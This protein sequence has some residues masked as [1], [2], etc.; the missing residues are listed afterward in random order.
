MRKDR[1]CGSS[2]GSQIEQTSPPER[3]SEI[4]L[5]LREWMDTQQEALSPVKWL[6][7]VAQPAPDSKLDGVHDLARAALNRSGG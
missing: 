1:P 7:T 6:L 5:A 3:T 2:V 4:A